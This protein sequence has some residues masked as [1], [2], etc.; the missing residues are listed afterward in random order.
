VDLIWN[1]I[2]PINN[3]GIFVLSLWFGLIRMDLFPF[4]IS[5]EEFL[6]ELAVDWELE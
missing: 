6:N 5:H 2:S 3:N 1:K 4:E